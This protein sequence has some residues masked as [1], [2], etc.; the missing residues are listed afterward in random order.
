M[1][2]H[3]ILET[4]NGNA[5]RRSRTNVAIGT[6][7][8]LLLGAAAGILLAPKSG[9]ETRQDIKKAAESGLEHV[10]QAAKTTAKFVKR[11]VAEVK[12]KVNAIKANKKHPKETLA[13]TAENTVDEVKTNA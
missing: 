11:E 13:E 9:K 4:L 12:E 2:V 8:G 1:I 5:K 10:N 7:V 3:E 6:A